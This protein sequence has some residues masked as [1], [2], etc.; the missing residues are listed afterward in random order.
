MLAFAQVPAVVAAFHNDI[1]LFPQIL[2][3]VGGP[4]GSGFAVEFFGEDGEVS[5]KF[6]VSDFAQLLPQ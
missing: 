5:G 1:D 6:T 3:D 4:M 2:S